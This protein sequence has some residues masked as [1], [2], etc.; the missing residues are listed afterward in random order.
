MSKGIKKYAMTVQNKVF[1]LDYKLLSFV[2]FFFNVANI[3][4]TRLNNVSE[5]RKSTCAHHDF[6]SMLLIIEFG[7]KSKCKGIRA[8]CSKNKFNIITLCDV[9]YTLYYMVK[10]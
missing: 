4:R 2:I 7:Q 10:N 8:T 1:I 5:R 3:L 6:I 9:N